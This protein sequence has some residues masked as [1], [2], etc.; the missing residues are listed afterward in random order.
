MISLSHRVIPS[1]I[2]LT[3]MSGAYFIT[4]RDTLSPR[5]MVEGGSVVL[6]PCVCF[7]FAL[8]PYC[9]Y[10]FLRYGGVYVI[11]TRYQVVV[12]PKCCN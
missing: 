4:F 1:Q 7:D 8:Q 11:N 12:A 3:A 2:V 9:Y 5:P 6:I 10:R